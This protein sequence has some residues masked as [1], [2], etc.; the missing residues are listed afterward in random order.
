MT[1]SRRMTLVANVAQI[2]KEL[3]LVIGEKAAEKGDLYEDQYVGG[4]IILRWIFG[5]IWERNGPIK[6]ESSCECGN[7]P[8]GSTQCLEVLG[9][10][11]N[12]WR[13]E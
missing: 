9:W 7:E 6:V 2:E 1:K 11:H 5:E 4:W 3:M 8:S 12:W 13:F 10:L